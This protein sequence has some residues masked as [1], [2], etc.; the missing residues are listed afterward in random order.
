MDER[1]RSRCSRLVPGQ[2]HPVQRVNAEVLS[3]QR[4]GVFRGKDPILDRSLRSHSI[5]R[6]V[7]A[8]IGLPI[9][10]GRIA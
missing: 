10:C 2:P 7:C 8:G 9:L 1:P 3:Q 6:C 4:H 5:K